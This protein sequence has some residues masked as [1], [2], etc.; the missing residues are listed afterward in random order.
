MRAR[1]GGGAAACVA[2]VLAAP[3][4]QGSWQLGKQE[5][6]CSRRVWQQYWPIHS[7]ILAWRTLLPDREAWQA[8]G[9]SLQG[10]KASDTTKAPCVHRHKA[11]SA[12]VRA[13]R[14]GGPAAWLAGTLAA[15]SVQGHGL[16]PPQASWPCQSLFEPLVAG[17]QRA[18]LASFSPSLRPF[19]HL[20]GSLASG[21]SL[22][23]GMS[24]T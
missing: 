20:E 9:R 1:C 23:F 2:G 14:E 5:I 24:G 16:P 13:E 21:P 4:T 22:L 7:S 6:Q 17:D 3:A 11:F 18:S 8:T 12:P 10:C 15:P 19:W